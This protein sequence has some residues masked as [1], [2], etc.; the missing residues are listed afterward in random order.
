MGNPDMACCGHAQGDVQG[1]GDGHVQGHVHA[2]ASTEFFI[3]YRI[4][5]EACVEDLAD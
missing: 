3:C 2:E 4:F 1:H 5:V